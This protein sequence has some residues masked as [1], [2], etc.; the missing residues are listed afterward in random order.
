M[1]KFQSSIKPVNI[2]L[3]EDNPGDVLLFSEFLKETKTSYT[4]HVVEDGE[5]ALMFLGQREK[6]HD[7]PRPDLIVLDLNLPKIDGF[8]VLQELK[9]DPQLKRIPVIILTSSHAEMDIE[10]SYDLHAN[11]YITKPSELK[12]FTEVVKAIEHFWIE[13]AS[14]PKR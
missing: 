7:K 5:E 13:I 9:Q 3:V 8:E 14:L 4:L 2:L 1:N 11:C 10:K 12:E 6:Y